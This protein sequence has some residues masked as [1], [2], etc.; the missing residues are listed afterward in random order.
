MPHAC[1][2]A[3][4]AIR[5]MRMRMAAWPTMRSVAERPVQTA[6]TC[7][8]RM[9]RDFITRAMARVRLGSMVAR[10]TAYQ[11]PQWGQCPLME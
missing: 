10:S 9:G 11:W 4:R 1:Q 5:A 2:R 3:L 8:A 6:E 7:S